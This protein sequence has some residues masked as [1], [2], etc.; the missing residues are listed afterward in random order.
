M[1]EQDQGEMEVR[2][3]EELQSSEGTREGTY[4]RPPVDI[5]ETDEA[6]TVLADTPGCDPDNFEI[7]LEDNRLTIMAATDEL[8]DRWEP[9]YGEYRSG[10]FLREF[11]LGK[12]IDREKISAH[13]DGGVLE[14]RLPKN[15]KAKRRKIEIETG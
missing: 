1:S 8:E 12:T 2:K 6:I 11:Q 4:F 7:N 14:V 13:F 10:H 9:V 3:K 5:Y 15:Q